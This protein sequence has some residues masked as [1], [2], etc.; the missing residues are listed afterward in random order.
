MDEDDDIEA[1]ELLDKWFQSD[2][3]KQITQSAEN[4]DSDSLELMEQVNEQLGN[5]IFHLKNQS[6][7][8]K[9]VTELLFFEQL[10]NDFEIL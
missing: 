9:I 8:N 6:P 10:C 3:W 4:G 2:V 7:T 5:L 1:D